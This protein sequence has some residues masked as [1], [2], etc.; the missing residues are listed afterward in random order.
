MPPPNEALSKDD[1]YLLLESYKNSVEMNTLISQQLSTILEMIA[2]CK[3]DNATL[4][5]ILKDKYDDIMDLLKEIRGKIEAHEKESIKNTGKILNRV[6]LLYVAIGSIV[7]G[8]VWMVIKYFD[9]LSLIHKIADK[10][11][12]S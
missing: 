12:V 7:L 11:G 10:L 9:E 3:D 5:S 8:L 4:E 2:Q 6:N 1:L